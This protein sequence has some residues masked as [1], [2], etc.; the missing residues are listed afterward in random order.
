MKADHNG[1]N[2]EV[3]CEEGAGFCQLRL[4]IKETEKCNQCTAV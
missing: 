2:R 3:R 4:G 1:E